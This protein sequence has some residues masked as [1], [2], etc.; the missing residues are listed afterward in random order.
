MK[1]SEINKFSDD[2]NWIF[3]FHGMDIGESFFIPSVKP[4]GLIYTIKTLSK[5]AGVRVEVRNAIKDGILGIRTWR[6]A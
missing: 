6:T 2:I 5:I 4:A 3:P 1:I